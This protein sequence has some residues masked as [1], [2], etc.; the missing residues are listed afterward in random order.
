MSNRV[1]R[2]CSKPGVEVEF[3]VGSQDHEKKLYWTVSLALLYTC[4]H[5]FASVMPILYRNYVFC[6]AMKNFCGPDRNT[7]KLFCMSL[8]P[9]QCT[10]LRII[11]IRVSLVSESLN[12]QDKFLHGAEF[13][14]DVFVQEHY[15]ELIE[16]NSVTD[17]KGLVTFTRLRTLTFEFEL[18]YRSFANKRELP[19]LVAFEGV[20][21][22]S[23]S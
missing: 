2:E 20:K 5:I 1:I 21:H 7:P 14:D 8:T 17:F 6:L 22:L 9:L 11:S 10:L 18:T 13:F 4:R 15:K 23:Y 16:D 3:P 19:F 12:W